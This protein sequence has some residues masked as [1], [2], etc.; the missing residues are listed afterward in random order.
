MFKVKNFDLE[1]FAQSSRNRDIRG[2]RGILPLV[3]RKDSYAIESK[4]QFY[5]ANAV[6]GIT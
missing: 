6:I 2:W 3:E 5:G 1:E 4:I